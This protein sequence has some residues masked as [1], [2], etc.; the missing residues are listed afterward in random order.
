MRNYISRICHFHKQLSL[1]PEALESFLLPA[2]DFMMRIY[3][4]PPPHLTTPSDTA[5]H[6]II[7]HMHP[8]ACN[9]CVPVPCF[10]CNAQAEQPCS[11]SPPT[12]TLTPT[13]MPVKAHLGR[14]T[15]SYVGGEIDS[16]TP[17]SW[18]NFC[19]PH[20]TGERTSSRPCASLQ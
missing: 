18:I 4:A 9:E 8:G 7:K 10:L 11:H 15:W 3:R 2:S 17:R 19:Y 16:N 20:S 12:S 6:P 13:D 1:I 14:P 5:L